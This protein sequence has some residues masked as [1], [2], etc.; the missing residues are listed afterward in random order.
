MVLL[1]PTVSEVRTRSGRLVK[2]P[3]RYVP[4]EKPN[5]DYSD[6]GGDADD[7]QT[8]SIDS[9]SSVSED[10][11]EDEEGN[12]AGFVIADSSEWDDETD[13]DKEIEIET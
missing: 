3:V 11:D 2:A 6:D 7:D 4:I 5:D 9:E 10:S 13:N 12:L 1:N 8:A